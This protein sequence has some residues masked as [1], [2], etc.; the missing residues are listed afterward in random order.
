MIEG[1]A[2]GKAVGRRGVT[3]MDGWKAEVE[4]AAA[5]QRSVALWRTEC[6]GEQVFLTGTEKD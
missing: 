4:T 1:E 2:N 6:E 5:Q 3:E